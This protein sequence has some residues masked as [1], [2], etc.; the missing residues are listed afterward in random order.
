MKKLMSLFHDDFGIPIPK[1]IL[2]N[3]QLM[4]LERKLKRLLESLNPGR[5]KQE[6]H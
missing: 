4:P 6:S 5:P 2:I 3:E 1:E